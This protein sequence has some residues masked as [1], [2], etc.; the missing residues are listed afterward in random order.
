MRVLIV[1]D[2]DIFRK[3]LRRLLET[4]GIQVVGEAV[5]GEAAVVAAAKLQPDVVL[6]DYHMPIM[7]GLAAARRITAAPNHIPVVVLTSDPRAAIDDGAP[8]AGVA[9]VLQKGCSPKVLHAALYA[10]VR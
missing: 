7:D 2:N 1:D 8:E 10:A 4:P 3:L 5:N 6:S 9:Q